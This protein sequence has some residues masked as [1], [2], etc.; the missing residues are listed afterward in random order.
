MA[1]VFISFI[2]EEGAV[3]LAMQSVPNE[4]IGDEHQAFLAVD[5]WCRASPRVN[6]DS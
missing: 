5:N 4:R 3:A 1:N 2:H 6:M